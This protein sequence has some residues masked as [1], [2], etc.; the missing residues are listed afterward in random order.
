[1][2]QG[3]RRQRGVMLFY[4]VTSIVVVTLLVTSSFTSGDD[5]EGCRF[6]DFL[7]TTLRPPGGSP[8]RIRHIIRELWRQNSSAILNYIV[9]RPAASAEKIICDVISARTEATLR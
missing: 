7:Q 4:H 2:E 5:S 1:M 6:P 8:V 9:C 3:L